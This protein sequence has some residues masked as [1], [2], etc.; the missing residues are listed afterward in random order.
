MS[1]PAVVLGIDSPI[2][3]TVVRDLGK[4]GIDVVGIGQSASALGMSSRYLKQGL[5]RAP[6]PEAIIAQLEALGAQ[7]GQAC[8]FAISENDIE[9]LNRYRDRLS[10]F[11]CMFADKARMDS[12]LN[13]DRTFAV[14]AQ[15]GIRTPRTEQ[16]TELAEVAALAATLRFPVVLKW[17]NP[18][19]A[20]RTLWDAG[21]QVDKT[22]FCHTPAALLA[23]LGQFAKVGIYPLIQEYCA[24]YGLGQFI[25][26]KD[27][28][29]HATFQHKRV[30]EWPP[31]GGFSSMCESLPHD[32]HAQLMAQS[33]ALLRA[34]AWE[35][36]AMVEYRHDPSTGQSALMEVN[37]R[38]WGSLPLA[39]HAGA[40]FASLSYQLLGA[41]SPVQ[42]A[43]YRVGVRC[44][45]MVPETRRLARILFAPHKIVDRTLKFNKF[46]ELFGYLRDFVRPGTRYY[47][48]EL[49]DPK[50][51]FS[52]LA[53]MLGKAVR[54]LRPARRLC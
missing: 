38:Y 45:Y 15:V 10:A 17:A 52:D 31:E 43:P 37:G 18:Q 34:L 50:P 7:L 20:A 1:L 2:G 8:L 42:M 6:D 54:S 21:L 24:G 29:A 46:A 35:G 5:V 22:H 23:Y 44:R 14:A 4:Q 16:V 36:V 9:M 25:L 26:M 33:V 3:L 19:G 41:G 49:A 30:H 27:G 28:V 32:Q 48:F 12:V 53:Q 40:G 11:R 47:V 39:Y 13:K 51:F